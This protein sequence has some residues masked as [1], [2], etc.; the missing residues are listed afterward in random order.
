MT[1]SRSLFATAIGLLSLV[2][3]SCQSVPKLPPPVPVKIEGLSVVSGVFQGRIEA[4][5][6]VTGYLSNGASQL[7]E[8]RQWREGYRLYIEL[9][10]QPPGD[11]V[12]G[13]TALVPFQRRI[14]IEIGGLAPG[15]YLIH[16]NGKEEHL[17][18]DGAGLRPAADRGQFL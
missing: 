8:P 16:V 13:T 2:W 11:G 3:T 15:V 14:P 1:L 4:Y 10:E 9:T 6:D 18:I 17:E 7:L 12:V 5:A